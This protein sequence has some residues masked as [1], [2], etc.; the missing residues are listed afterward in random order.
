MICLLTP[1]FRATLY[2]IYFPGVVVVTY[3]NMDIHFICL[4]MILSFLSRNSAIADKPR[5][6]FRGQS[7]SPNIVPFHMLCM[8][9]Y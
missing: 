8:V 5:E 4:I 1:E 9:S 7:R 3:V 6:T 2:I